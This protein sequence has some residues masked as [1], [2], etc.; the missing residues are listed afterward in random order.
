MVANLFELGQKSIE[1]VREAITLKKKCIY[2]GRVIITG[3]ISMKQFVLN[4][5]II[6]LSIPQKVSIIFRQ[7]SKEG[8]SI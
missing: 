7:S 2:I 3:K 4:L 1:R 6:M 5:I 8:L